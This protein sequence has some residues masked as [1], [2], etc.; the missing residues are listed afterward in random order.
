MRQTV[1]HSIAGAFLRLLF[2]P[3]FV[4]A[5]LSTTAF[6]SPEPTRFL[7]A[8]CQEPIV[9]ATRQSEQTVASAHFQPHMLYIVNKYEDSF[10]PEPCSRR[11]RRKF[12]LSEA[13][14]A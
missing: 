14:A 7:T 5:M 12:F 2:M 4:L 13:G 9:A 6:Q 10:P 3:V 8:L 11:S 1:G